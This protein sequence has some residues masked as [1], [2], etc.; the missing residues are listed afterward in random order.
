[1]NWIVAEETGN[2]KASSSFREKR[3]ISSTGVDFAKKLLTDES[4]IG[5]RTLDPGFDMKVDFYA[6][7]NFV[8]LN[9][10]RGEKLIARHDETGADLS[11]EI[12]EVGEAHWQPVFKD[13]AG[14]EVAVD[15]VTSV[16]MGADGKVKG[17]GKLTVVTLPVGGDFAICGD[18]GTHHFEVVP[19]T[20]PWRDLEGW[21][22]RV[23]LHKIGSPETSLGADSRR[24][25][26]NNTQ[27]GN[28]YDDNPDEVH[29]KDGT[30]LRGKITSNVDFHHEETHRAGDSMVVAEG[31]SH[32][33]TGSLSIKTLMAMFATMAW[34]RIAS[35]RRASQTGALATGETQDTLV[36]KDGTGHWEFTK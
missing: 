30:I 36:M 22:P 1:M 9:K 19:S 17:D 25:S 27:A 15:K 28:R 10:A 13:A 34:I 31:M 12:K 32:L 26:P 4:A 24:F 6:W 11:V 35:I 21:R 29:L 18:A 2:T 20:Q 5:T 7:N 23:Q 16:V 14:E 3:A 33:P 8:N